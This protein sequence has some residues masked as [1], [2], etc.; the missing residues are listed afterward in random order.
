MGGQ[1]LLAHY[2]TE[3]DEAVVEA[4]V[5]AGDQRQSRHGLAGHGLA[6]SL[7]P[8]A[9]LALGHLRRGV[10][11]ER[12]RH[13]VAHRLRQVRQRELAHLGGDGLED[14]PVAPRLPAGRHRRLQRVDVGVHVGGVEIVL[15]VPGGRREDDVGVEGRGVHAEIEV[16][17]EVELP[18]GSVPP[19]DFP[20]RVP[21][22][23][24]G[25]AVVVRSEVVLEEVL[26]PLGARHERV[27]PP[28]EPQSG[29]ALRGVGI[30]HR[31]AQLLLA[32]LPYHPAHHLLI[33]LR[34]SRL[35]LPD[36]LGGVPVE[37]R[38]EGQPA[39]AHRPHLV[40]D[41]MAGGDGSPGG[42]RVHLFLVDGPLVAP[43]VAVHVVEA[44]GVLQARRA[45]PVEGE[46]ER[47]PGRH[48]GELLLADVVVEP[49]AVAPDAAAQHEAGDGGTV[50]E[51]AVVPLVHARADDD[52]A[53]AVGA[54]G[55]LR[56][57][58]GE[59]HHVCGGH[60][61]EA[62]L[63]GR[64]VGSG[65]VVVARGIVAGQ[66]TRDAVLR[67]QEVV[68]RR[69][70]GPTAR[71]LD[72]PHRHAAERDPAA[73]VVREGHRGERVVA[74]DEREL[75]LDGGAVGAVLH[76]QVPLALS[77]LPAEA[78]GALWHPRR[79]GG[80]VPDE[81]LEVAVLGAVVAREPARREHPAGSEGA[82]P[83]LELHQEGRVAVA[84]EVLLEETHLPLGV[85]LLQDDMDHRHPEGAILAGVKRD[86]PIGVLGGHA[87]VGGEHH[88]LGAVVAGLGDEVHVGRPGHPQVGAHGDD[89]LRVIPV[90][91]LGDIGL[92][93]PDL[94]RGVGKVAVP[95]VE[96]E[97]H[98]AEELQEARAGR[99]GEH[100]HRRDGREADDAVGAVALD[101]V[102]GRGGHQLQRLVP[103][104]PPEPALAAGPLVASALL[105]VVHDGGPGGDRIG[106]AGPRRAPQVHERA[107]QVGVFH[108]QRAVEVP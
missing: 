59:A 106:V 93:A 82:V 16:H 78:E 85:E 48:R 50:G 7:R 80:P 100:R 15:L 57:L 1:A 96:G 35:G 42:N 66:A 84:L 20:H 81:E 98:R 53:P 45:R 10:V 90:G 63:P 40:V 72:V 43:L 8:V 68:D 92:L 52:A 73:R 18:L 58:A 9:D 83:L 27:G 51:V 74:L 34:A 4:R 24:G 71:R 67:E 103:G 12:R 87:E 32:E 33:G 86:P 46:R 6:L 54:L 31:E 105:G 55:R 38:E 39:E 5:V 95:V 69:H 75:G 49:A 104:G 99:E 3:G 23:L 88:Q 89:V 70:G 21:G 91:A 22:G 77:L 97:V 94:R 37:L 101:G 13:D 60:A 44:R 79:G 11:L 76:L 62:F 28:D 26:V 47:R 2:R 65:G 107:A 102:D 61:G 17:D 41:G 29:P 36:H 30:L 19:G 108:A 56:P 64:S 14:L 25:D